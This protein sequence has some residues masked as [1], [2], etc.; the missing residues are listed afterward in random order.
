MSHVSSILSTLSSPSDLEQCKFATTPAACEALQED[1]AAENDFAD[2]LGQYIVSL[3]ALRMRRH[4]QLLVGYP[5][6]LLRVFRRD[7]AADEVLKRFKLDAEIFAELESMTHRSTALEALYRRHLSRKTSVKQCLAALSELDY[8]TST[9]F[10]GM[11]KS[12][13]SGVLVTQSI[14]DIIGYQKNNKAGIQNKRFRRPLWSMHA[15]L[16]AKVLQERHS[17]QTVSMDIPLRGKSQ[18][19]PAEAFSEDA[20]Q[21]SLNF[22]E[23]ASTKA[24]ADWWSPCPTN[25]NTPAA[26]LATLR[27]LKEAGWELAGQIKFNELFK[28]KHRFVFRSVSGGNEARWYLPLSAFGDSSILVI[29]CTAK[30][31]PGSNDD[32]YYDID[33]P[34]T[35]PIFQTITDLKDIVACASSGGARRGSSCRP[36][37]S[38]STASVCGRSRR[39]A[40]WRCS[41]WLAGRPFG[42]SLGQRSPRWLMGR[43]SRWR[44]PPTYSR[45]CSPSL[46]AG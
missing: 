37:A 10:E 18:R 8:C 6:G 45:C 5:L 3:A 41:T 46:P 40:R 22:K 19:V 9:D 7:G 29:P 17:Y 4:L 39:W 43:A 25:N 38:S 23:I 11:L 32:T 2:V 15:A 42:R 21:R 12:H 16:K 28:H 34:M 30:V 31:L 33:L 14:E 36:R 20:K 27:M 24:S 44:S 13:T 35:D 1:M 26:D